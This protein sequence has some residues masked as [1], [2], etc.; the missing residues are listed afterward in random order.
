MPCTRGLHETSSWRPCNQVRALGF[1]PKDV[2]HVAMT[3]LDLDHVGGLSDFPWAAV[4]VHTPGAG[5]CAGSGRGGNSRGRYKPAMWKHGPH[6]VATDTVGEDWFGFEAVRDLA[7]LPPEI[8]LVPL[9]GHSVGHCPV[10]V[11]T[12]DRWLLAAGDAY[13]DPREVH[14]PVRECSRQLERFQRFVTADRELW[15]HNQGQLRQLVAAREDLTVF[16][17]HDPWGPGPHSVKVISTAVVSS[18]E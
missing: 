10:A 6:F 16:S 4:H 14:K 11:Q 17:A 15:R 18:G 5:R 12:P 3:R 7:G 9:P 13:F 8:L 2:R 1:D